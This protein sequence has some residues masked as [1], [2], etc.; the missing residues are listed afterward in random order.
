MMWGNY[1][2]NAGMMVWGIIMSLLWLSLAAM[3]V[4]ALL[5]WLGRASRPIPPTQMP[6][7]PSP[8]DIL[9][10]RYARGEIDTA[11]YQSMREHLE[12]S[13]GNEPAPNDVVPSGR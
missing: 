1:Y 7:Q 4:W 2:N 8:L 9:N 6:S 3:A 12:A 10:V 13:T 11:M 5:R